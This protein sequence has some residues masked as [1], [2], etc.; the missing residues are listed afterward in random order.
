MRRDKEEPTRSEYVGCAFTDFKYI[1]VDTAAGCV[2]SLCEGRNCYA[3]VCR[4]GCD[5]ASVSNVAAAGRL[6]KPHRCI[7]ANR[8]HNKRYYDILRCS[9]SRACYNNFNLIPLSVGCG[10]EYIKLNQLRVRGK[11]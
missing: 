4:C 11:L 6:P 5:C 8:H 1:K 7:S 10:D 2:Y 3:E 9:C